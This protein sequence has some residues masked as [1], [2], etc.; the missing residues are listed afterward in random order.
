MEAGADDCNPRPARLRYTLAVNLRGKPLAV[1]ARHP[2]KA[3]IPSQPRRMFKRVRWRIARARSRD[4]GSQAWLHVCCDRPRSRKSRSGLPARR[5]VWRSSTIARIK[6]GHPWP[7]FSQEPMAEH[8]LTNIFFEQF[9]LHP[10]LAQ[11]IA[12]TGF[13]RCTPIQALTLPVALEGRDV[14][15]QA[16][17]GTGKTCA[18]LVAVF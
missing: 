1:S 12:E 9:D 2:H 6:S 16:Q 11:G 15:G 8:V 7:H 14:A 4:Q 10:L 17:T 3:G 18:F 13:V 5:F